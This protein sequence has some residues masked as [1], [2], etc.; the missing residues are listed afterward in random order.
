MA[1]RISQNVFG[2]TLTVYWFGA[3]IEVSG[4]WSV[5]SQHVSLSAT[6]SQTA[7]WAAAAVACVDEV[8]AASAEFS[9]EMRRFY[10]RRQ[11]RWRRTR[12][13]KAK[14][15][16]L[17]RIRAAAA[18]YSPIRKAIEERLA[19]AEAVRREKARRAYEEQERRLA[20]ARAR[21]AAWQERQAVADRPLLGGLTPRELADRGEDPPAWPREVRDAV[22]DVESWWAEVVAWA[23]NERALT[24][25]VRKV[26]S[27]ITATAAALEAA[28]R[29]GVTAVKDK[30]W[31]VRR[32]WWIDF[33]WTDLPSSE[34]LCTPPDAPVGH[35]LAGDWDYD[36]YRPRRILLTPSVLDKY[37]L[38]TVTSESIANGLATRYRW[39]T[40]DI[41]AF[42]EGIFPIRLT[43]RQ[44][45]HYSGDLRLRLPRHA[46][47][48]VYIPYVQAV[49]ERAAATFTA[50]APGQE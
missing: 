8:S 38:A 50:L 28:G 49:A 4:L 15:A 26:V 46:D 17:S 13:E 22:G 16:Y 23:R 2:E 19:Q 33:D 35:L 40:R 9:P 18:A 41:E 7:A 44:R 45:Y 48:A 34:P 39:W 6:E 43:Y 32:G 3:R 24:T 10:R 37:E 25:S 12:Y 47:P 31:E 30:P 29:P 36:R 1:L 42:A 27:A 20:E 11:W 14:A 5:D 21:F